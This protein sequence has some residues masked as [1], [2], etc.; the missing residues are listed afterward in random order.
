MRILI[1]TP[2]YAPDIGPSAP[3]F[4]LLSTALAQKGH[5][6]TVIAAVPHYSTGQVPP[7]YRKKW[8][9]RSTEN[10]VNVIR[11]AVPSLKR[12][13]FSNR[14]IQFLCFQIGA[15]FTSLFL[16]FDAA[17]ITNPAIETWLPMMLHAVIRRKPVILSVFDV[18]PDVGIKLGVFRNRWVIAI[19]AALEKSCLAP[20]ASVHIIS[21]NFKT[22]LSALNVPEEKMARIDLWVDTDLIT[23]GARLNAF[24]EEFGLSSKFVVLYAGN[25]GMSQGLEYVIEAARECSWQQD[26]LFV[27]VGDGSEKED[28]QKRVNQAGLSNVRFIPF[29]PRERLAEVL[30]TADVALICLRRGIGSE[31]LPSK[32]FSILASGRPI[33]ACVEETSELSALLQRASAGLVVPPEDAQAITRAVLRLKGSPELCRQMGRNGREYVV[34]QHGVQRA[35]QDFEN[36]LY[37]ITTKSSCI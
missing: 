24:S 35:R 25:L 7:E 13:H 22:S 4:T 1:I 8:V 9:Y 30:A 12:A 36:I 10:G 6:V 32:T 34:E 26:I 31:S 29:Q 11:V 2:F 23:P 37:K 28:L 19:I 27:L 16:K 14:M 15:F 17:I 20:A 3:L 5:Q 21:D 33:L 18:Y